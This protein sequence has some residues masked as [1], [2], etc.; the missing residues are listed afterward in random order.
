M[1]R[2]MPSQD[3]PSDDTN[4]TDEEKLRREEAGDASNQDEMFT[5][6]Y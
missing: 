2:D 1:N 5:D 6:E 4:K 3:N